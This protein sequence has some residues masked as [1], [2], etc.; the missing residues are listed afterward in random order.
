MKIMDRLNV[1]TKMDQNYGRS[2]MQLPFHWPNLG[3]GS[4][5]K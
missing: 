2:F 1:P 5:Q 4:K 3:I